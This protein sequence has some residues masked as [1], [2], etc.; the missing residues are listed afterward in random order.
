MNNRSSSHSLFSKHNKHSPKLPQEIFYAVGEP[1]AYVTGEHGVSGS[2]GFIYRDFIP[3]KEII[4]A[5]PKGK[6][7][8]L[9]YKKEDALEYARYLRTG[10]MYD[11]LKQPA[12]YKVQCKNILENIQPQEEKIIINADSEYQ[13]RHDSKKRTSKITYFIANSKNVQPLEGQLKIHES[14]KDTYHDYEIVDFSNLE[15]RFKQDKCKLYYHDKCRLFGRIVLATAATAS[16]A[17]L[18]YLATH[19]EISFKH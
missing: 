2:I 16:V 18:A 5:F 11:T 15:A 14:D 13:L 12:I 19:L 7:I 4:N 9:F 10:S 6:E 3:A 1:I 17:G 8:K